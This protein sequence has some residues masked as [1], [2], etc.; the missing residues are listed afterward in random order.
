[1]EMSALLKQAY[2][3]EI[4]FIKEFHSQYTRQFSES[5]LEEDNPNVKQMID[6]MALFMAR[7]RLCGKRQ[8][9][10]LHHR[11]FHQLLPYLLSPVP[12]KGLIKLGVDKLIEPTQINAGTILVLSSSDDVQAKFRTLYDMPVQPLSLQRVGKTAYQKNR[13]E[14]MIRV[15]ALTASPGKLDRLNIFVHGQGN[16]VLSLTLLHLFKKYTTKI[17]AN[18]DAGKQIDCAYSLGAPDGLDS[19][20]SAQE[21]WNVHPLEQERSFF[22]LPQQT[23][24]LNLKLDDAPTQWRYCDISISLCCDWP[25]EI[26]L[27]SELFHLFVIPVENKIMDQA[28]PIQCDGTQSQYP[29][30]SPVV[31]PELSLCSVDGVYQVNTGE[32]IPIRPGI[33]KDGLN[34]YQLYPPESAN[35]NGDNTAPAI[36]LNLPQAFHQPQKVV[37]D[38]F[39]HHP[40]F[41][42]VIGDKINVRPNDL[43]IAGLTWSLL[44]SGSGQLVSYI[45][46]PECLPEKYLELSALKNKAILSFN[47]MAI[48]LDS[49]TS[50]WSGEYGALREKLKDLRV[51]SNQVDSEQPCLVY[52]V[53]FFPMDF[54]LMLLADSFLIH[55]QTILDNWIGDISIRVKAEFTDV[56]GKGAIS[57]TEAN[58]QLANFS[59][60]EDPNRLT[61]GDNVF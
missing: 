10:Q 5:R 20:N 21:K 3:E 14:L 34:S 7:S 16:Y 32:R 52:V 35:D 57:P 38:G 2:K 22:H 61:R 29:I 49:F 4:N 44:S 15:L 37:V 19:E 18:F 47:E 17:S 55:L 53:V 27:A 33:V 41:S 23:C 11:V 30:L 36:E 50:I 42:Q 43:D 60:H 6:S 12:A 58:N 46:A 40:N 9:K 51:I 1:M 26:Q 45:P 24:Y 31:D 48:I 59:I 39:W 56:N 25:E 28:Q 8:I 13:S 54:Q